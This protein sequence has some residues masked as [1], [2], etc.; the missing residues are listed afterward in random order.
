MGLTAKLFDRRWFWVLIVPAISYWMIPWQ[1]GK[2]L[3]TF[4]DRVLMLSLVSSGTLL[5][6]L[7]FR[8]K[9]VL[10]QKLFGETTPQTNWWLEQLQLIVTTVLVCIVFTLADKLAERLPW[11][12]YALHVTAGLAFGYWIW[13]TV[14]VTN[15]KRVE[16]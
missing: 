3:V 14:Y 2:P 13:R 6:W 5:L 11:P 15:L 4:Q 9:F 10:H 8:Q 1:A 12:G 7:A 16:E